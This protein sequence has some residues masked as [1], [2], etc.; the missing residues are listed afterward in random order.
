MVGG[1]RAVR[2]P[3]VT[4]HP[5]L[6]VERAVV[7]PGGLLGV[8]PEP[9]AQLTGAG[10]RVGRVVRR[11]VVR[12][13]G[14]RQDAGD[15]GAQRG[16]GVG[17]DAQ[18]GDQPGVVDGGEERAD[19]VAGARPLGEDRTVVRVVPVEP[20]AV[21]ALQLL[22]GPHGALKTS[23][24]GVVVDHPEPGGGHRRPEAAADVGGGGLTRL[25]GGAGPADVDLVDGETEVGRHGLDRAIRVA[26][27]AQQQRCVRAAHGL[28]GGARRGGGHGAERQ[29]GG[30][31]SRGGEKR[32]TVHQNPSKRMSHRLWAVG[33]FRSSVVICGRGAPLP[34][35]APACAAA[36]EQGWTRAAPH[37]GTGPER[38]CCTG[39]GVRQVSPVP[40]RAGAV[41]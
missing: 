5:R 6:G 22:D 7:V 27:P 18:A 9:A 4:G 12:P 21:V 40:V 37:A 24:H 23:A 29:G 14:G 13:V 32:T 34:R 17:G 26:E 19:R 35:T 33:G 36:R 20:E 39:T 8:G 11:V 28:G 1:Q 16:C 30:P 31:C 2:D 25:D 41:R 3:Q 10:D 15:A 38:P